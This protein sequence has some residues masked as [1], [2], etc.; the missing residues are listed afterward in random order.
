MWCYSDVHGTTHTGYLSVYMQGTSA[1]PRT[2][3]LRYEPPASVD[4]L[5]SSGGSTSSVMCRLNCSTVPKCLRQYEHPVMTTLAFSSMKVD[6]LC[7]P[8]SV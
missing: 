1:Y 8:I 2:G 4:S 7:F 5:S 3:R 6:K